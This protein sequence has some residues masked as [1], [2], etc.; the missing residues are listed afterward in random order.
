MKY[1]NHRNRRRPPRPVSDRLT[2][3]PVRNDHPAESSGRGGRARTVPDCVGN[4]GEWRG[5]SRWPV[6]P[7]NGQPQVSAGIAPREPELP[8][9]R[10]RVRFP[11]PLFKEGPGQRPG[12]SSLS[13][14]IQAPRTT[15]LLR[16]LLSGLFA[17]DAHHLVQ[18]VGDLPPSLRTGRSPPSCPS[19]SLRPASTGCALYGEGRRT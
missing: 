13:R 11:S 8:K 1:S 18:P 3:P 9:L 4:H 7:R 15:W 5:A 2:S 10:A 6:G 16:G 12:P 17:G 14:P 19:A